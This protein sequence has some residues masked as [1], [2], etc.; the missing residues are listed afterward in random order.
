MGHDEFV[1]RVRDLGSLDS[2]ERAESA[3]HTTLGT[4]NEHL[5]GGEP[6]NL[7]AQLPPEIARAPRYEG[8]QSGG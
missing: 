1:K 7:A 2:R 3:I 5:A 8:E 4:L 6:R